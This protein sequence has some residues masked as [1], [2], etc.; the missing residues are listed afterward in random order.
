MHKMIE[1]LP[2][3]TTYQTKHKKITGMGR[4]GL[5]KRRALADVADELWSTF[6]LCACETPPGVLCPAL[7]SSTQ[8]GHGPVGTGPAEGHKDDPKDGAPPL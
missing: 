8:E 7:E 3:T 1:T 2:V 4:K 5:Q 6:I